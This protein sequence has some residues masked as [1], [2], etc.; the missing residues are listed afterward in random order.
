MV[1]RLK[2]KTE[3]ST[4]VA[5][6]RSLILRIFHVFIQNLMLYF[7][8]L[9]VVCLAVL[10]VVPVPGLS[11][12]FPVTSNQKIKCDALMQY[13][14]TLDRNNRTAAT[15]QPGNTPATLWVGLVACHVTFSPSQWRQLCMRVHIGSLCIPKSALDVVS[16][17]LSDSHLA[18]WR[19]LRLKY[20]Y[21]MTSAATPDAQDGRHVMTP[22]MTSGTDRSVNLVK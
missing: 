18:R 20:L 14:R 21:L 2:V 8:G 9:A 13:N 10:S 19:R 12:V 1:T 6:P 7:S 11:S 3:I 16:P 22:R 4:R 5:A 15:R 17:P